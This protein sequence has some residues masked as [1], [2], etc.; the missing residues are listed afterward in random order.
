M[1]RWR[2]FGISFCILPSFWF[3]NVLWALLMAGPMTQHAGMDRFIL[4]FIA[5]WIACALVSSMVHELGHAIMGRIFGEPGNITLGGGGQ[6]NV[7][8]YAGLRPWQRIIIISAGPAAGFTFLALIIALD[9]SAWNNFMDWLI[10][11]SNSMF[12]DDWKIRLFWIDKTALGAYRREGNFPYV[13]MVNLLTF[14]NLFINLLNLFPI[15][16]LDGGMIL[17]ELCCLISPQH[18]LKAAFGVSFLLAATL[19]VFYLDLTLEKYNIMPKRLEHFYPFGFPEFSLILFVSLTYQCFQAYRQLLVRDRHQA[20]ME[21]DDMSGPRR[22]PAGVEEVP[23]KDPDDF[24]PRARAAKGRA[25]ND[26]RDCD[27]HGT[28]FWGKLKQGARGEVGRVWSCQL[29][30]HVRNAR[31]CFACRMNWRGGR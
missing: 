4:I 27:S 16:P 5:A 13:V 31:P 8:A 17:K 12:F 9:S 20:Y 2:I 10:Q 1:L 22:L 15:I 6:G 30:R 24:A 23:V 25:V 21:D 7:G 26:F 28:A 18:G 14:V 11:I 29:R 19:S 3:M